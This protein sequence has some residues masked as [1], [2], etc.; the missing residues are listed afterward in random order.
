M[1]YKVKEI[2]YTLQG[3]GVHTGRAAVFVRF[4]GCNLW[5]GRESDRGFGIGSCSSWCDTDFTG[6]DTVPTALALVGKALDVWGNSTDSKNRFVVLTGG[7]P[8]LQVD[9]TLCAALQANGF[10][11]SIETNGTCD[12]PD[13]IDWIC[14]SPKTGRPLKLKGCDELK[15]VYPQSTWLS[16]NDYADQISYIW[17]TVS[18]LDGHPNSLQA[19]VE[20]CKQNPG[21]RLSLQ[22]HKI[23]GLA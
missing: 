19:C 13:G 23:L 18:P 21:W 16:P 9:S 15:V 22:T 17:K 14:C 12:L 4:A 20:F 11:V 6:G 7:E 5:S 2:F 8:A 1:S 10:Y 3:E